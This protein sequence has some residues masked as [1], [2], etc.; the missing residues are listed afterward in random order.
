M[1]FMLFEFESSGEGDS[2]LHCHPGRRHRQSSIISSVLGDN[3]TRAGDT[4]NHP[5]SPLSLLSVFLYYLPRLKY[6]S[7]SSSNCFLVS[8]IS[9]QSSVPTQIKTNSCIRGSRSF[10][11]LSVKSPASEDRSFKSL[12]SAI[13]ILETQSNRSLVCYFLISREPTSYF[14]FVRWVIVL[15]FYA[16]WFPVSRRIGVVVKMWYYD[17]CRISVRMVGVDVQKT[18]WGWKDF[19][20]IFIFMKGFSF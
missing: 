8:F 20:R 11:M 16:S 19:Q 17:I 12:A 7:P 13:L 5:L 9:R 1:N 10:S 18:R 4:G 2:C 3:V 6:R 14:F 15:P